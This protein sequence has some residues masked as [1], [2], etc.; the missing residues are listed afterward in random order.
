MSE[1]I[2]AIIQ[3]DLDVLKDRSRTLQQIV[4]GMA[5]GAVALI[6]VLW[7]VFSSHSSEP[8]HT[9]ML[10]YV[11]QVE[12]AIEARMDKKD[13]LMAQ[14]IGDLARARQQINELNKSLTRIESKL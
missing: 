7:T 13:Q 10:L 9:G 4:L 3:R 2:I 12:D 5:G 14:L 1:E 6:A 8:Y 11:S